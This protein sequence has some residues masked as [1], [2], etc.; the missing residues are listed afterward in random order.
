MPYVKLGVVH[1]TKKG[2]PHM[3]HKDNRDLFLEKGKKVNG[4]PDMRFKK[5]IEANNNFI[6]KT[7]KK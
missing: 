7:L 6:L 4:E 3:T 1:F 2:L 5:N